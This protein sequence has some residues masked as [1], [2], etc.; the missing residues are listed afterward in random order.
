MTDKM[1]AALEQIAGVT[2]FQRRFGTWTKALV[3]AGFTP[4]KAA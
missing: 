4:R 3:A 1:R 2:A